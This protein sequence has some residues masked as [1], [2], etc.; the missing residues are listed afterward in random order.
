[1]PGTVLGIG[2]YSDEQNRQDSC[3]HG[4]DILVG[5]GVQRQSSDKYI[6][7]Q[8]GDK[9][10]EGKRVRVKGWRVKE[11]LFYVGVWS[12]EVFLWR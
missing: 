6:I 1:M 4:A 7:C 5:M 2:R 10:C 8:V 9:C 11:R 3:P 12:G